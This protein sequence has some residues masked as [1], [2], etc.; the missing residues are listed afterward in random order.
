M[1]NERSSQ[2]QFNEP[3]YNAGLERANAKAEQAIPEFSNK[4]TKEFVE[5]AKNFIAGDLSE[6]PLDAQAAGKD[7]KAAVVNAGD[8]IGNKAEAATGTDPL[9]SAQESIKNAGADVRQAVFGGTPQKAGSAVFDA[10]AGVRASPASASP[11][12]VLIVCLSS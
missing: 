2:T 7:A 10:V 1:D 8:K 9:A 11:M 4:N 5:A 12:W 6:L 3:N